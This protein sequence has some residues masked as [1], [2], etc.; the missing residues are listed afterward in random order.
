[1][2]DAHT[3]DYSSINTT[4]N[5][6]TIKIYDDSSTAFKKTLG[7]WNTFPSRHLERDDV[8]TETVLFHDALL[9]LTDSINDL[10]NTNADNLKTYPIDCKGEETSKSGYIISN[11]MKIKHPSQDDT[12]SKPV[13][14]DQDGNRV[15][16][17]IYVVDNKR[18]E[19]MAVWNAQNK[20]LELKRDFNSTTNA[21]TENF[22]KIVVPVATT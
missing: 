1:M 4:V 20:T 8:K 17:N 9:L 7:R 16:F 2:K 12:I 19:Y 6:T 13:K 15:D 21:A 10:V 18:H 22:Q 3:L 5:I 11:Y 14:F